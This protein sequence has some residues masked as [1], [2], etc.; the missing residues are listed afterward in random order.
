VARTHLVA[1]LAVCAASAGQAQSA[2]VAERGTLVVRS[3]ASAAL[4]V[5]KGYQVY[6]PAAYA[7]DSTRRFPVAYL[8]HGR[9]GNETEWTA[10]GDLVVVADSLFSQGAPEL[11]L[12]MPDGDN[13]FWVNWESWPGLA[14]CA[15]DTTLAEAAES[16]CV[17]SAGYG[18]YVAHDLVAEVDAAFRTLAARAHRGLLGVSMGGTGA[19]T[20]AL[21]YADV[22]GATAAFAAPQTSA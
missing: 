7:H 10:R 12:V 22:F 11:I 2:A 15:R 18:D 9:S 17:E 21:G 14:A 16:F 3:F 20:L 13:S 19:L 4:G 5:R 8:L 1:L 6:L